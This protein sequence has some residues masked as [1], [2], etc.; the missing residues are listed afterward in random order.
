MSNDLFSSDPSKT[1]ASP[2]V[3]LVGEGKKFKT[4]DDLAIGKKEADAFIEQL[5]QEKAAMR[6]EL[7]A[8]S[9]K[10][11]QSVTLQAVLE[12]LEQAR[13]PNSDGK[14]EPPVINQDELKNMVRGTL[15]EVTKADARKTNR[16][17][18]NEE[19]LK[20]FSGDAEKA[21]QFVAS[22]AASLGL[23]K[24]A[25][26]DLSESSPAAFATLLGLTATS[27]QP[28][29][30]GSLTS[31]NSEAL[32]KGSLNRDESFFV[33]LKKT[34]KKEFW[35]A[36][37]QQELFRYAEKHGQEALSKILNG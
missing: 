30:T 6:A 18:A 24:E 14:T 20:K 2:L 32:N 3:D 15:E 29:A 16:T 34:N 19:V 27:T 25:L 12:K 31:V 7:E 9:K 1:Q 26:G 17:K 10:A 22:K 37:N 11:E 23:S 21:A 35:S 33:E 36:R 5:K 8:L 4:V 28:G 13:K